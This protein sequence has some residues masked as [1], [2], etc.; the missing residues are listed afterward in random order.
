MPALPSVD[1]RLL[2]I[3]HIERA[4]AFPG[5]RTKAEWLKRAADVRRQLRL[6]LGLWPEPPRGPLNPVV[7]KHTERDC[8]SIEN[9]YFESHPGFFVTGNLYRP[10]PLPSGKIPA[11]LVPHGHWK[12]GRLVNRAPDDDSMPGLCI[13]IALRGGMAFA[14]DMVG[15][16]DSCQLSHQFGKDDMEKLALWGI[17]LLGLQAFN[18]MRVA[19]YLLALPE[20]DPQRLAVTGASGGGTQT[21]LLAALDERLKASAPVVMVSSVMQGGCLC[22]NAPGLRIDTNNMEI[23]ALAAPRP[24]FIISCT[25]DWTSNTP[26]VEFPAVRRIYA[27]YGK[28]A[29]ARIENYHQ[30]AAHNYNRKS[31]EALY[32]WLGRI[33]FGIKDPAYAT[34]RD[35][36]VESL[37]S[38][39]VFP[40]RKPPA[41]KDEASLIQYLKDRALA[42]IDERRPTGAG[43]AAEK[44]SRPAL[45]RF[46][47]D[48]GPLL[49]QVL[50]AEQPLPKDVLAR[51]EAWASLGVGKPAYPKVSR[52]WLSRKNEGDLLHGVLAWPETPAKKVPL[53]IAVHNK[54]TWGLLDMTRGAPEALVAALLQRGAAVLVL[55]T[56]EANALFGKRAR[57]KNHDLAYNLASV[58]HRAQDILTAVG[59][60]KGQKKFSSV[61]L[62]GQMYAGGFTLLARTQA[63]GVRKTAIDANG[64]KTADDDAYFWDAC[65]PGLRLAGGLPAAAAFCAPGELYLHDTRDLF[66][67]SWALESYRDAKA[68]AKL[69]FAREKAGDADLAQWLLS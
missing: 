54:G 21:F 14:Y 29:A 32:G 37:D 35:F 47:K 1:L 48:A 28:P 15:Y 30:H 20:T 44:T 25:G 41:G 16:N 67:T 68:A 33:W 8:Y 53:V 4:Y 18:S 64:F 46:K 31:R 50:H 65:A 63:Q 5:F 27:L 51:E 22:E 2:D 42:W 6:A 39:R 62:A 61:S 17:S 66:D 40:D 60:A 11:L 13:N 69:K 56:H 38:L 36:T 43:D 58:C 23:P 55:D 49:A 59:W 3:R 34:E 24:Q 19:D 45:A 26:Q 12:E 9:V 10:H 52:L 57:V 7:T